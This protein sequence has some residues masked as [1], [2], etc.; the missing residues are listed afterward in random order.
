MTDQ[1]A[2]VGSLL[3]LP[4]L[5]G[6]SGRRRLIAAVILLRLLLALTA[7][8]ASL[9]GQLALSADLLAYLLAVVIV[10][11]IGGLYPALVAALA[12]AGLAD[13][14]MWPL[15]CWAVELAARL[16]RLAARALRRPRSAA[17]CSWR[18]GADLCQRSGDFPCLRGPVS[19]VQTAAT[20]RTVRLAW[21]F[22]MAPEAIGM[23]ANRKPRST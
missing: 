4:G 6:V 13:L 12:S 18:A 20:V 17:R 21:K 7:V 1:D 8:L 19:W 3:R 14:C 16:E 10:A 11:V 15:R 9:R 23:T 2:A 5:G 22:W